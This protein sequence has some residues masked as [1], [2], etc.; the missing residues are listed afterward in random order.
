MK[1]S[2]IASLSLAFVP[3]LFVLA[4]KHDIKNI[5]EAIDW[6]KGILELIV[7]LLVALA[8]F[9]V[10]WGVFEFVQSSGDEEKRKEGRDRMIYGLIGVVV[11]LSVYGLLSILMG[12]VALDTGFT[13]DIPKIL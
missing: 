2:I 11:M 12:S 1:K 10:I 5:T 8:I 3:T 6:V 4:S 13:P 9:Y 7:G